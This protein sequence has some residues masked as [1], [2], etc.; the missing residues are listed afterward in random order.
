VGHQRQPDQPGQQ[1]RFGAVDHLGRDV[2]EVVGRRNDVRRG[3]GRQVAM[4]ISAMA[5]ATQTG[6]W[7]WPIS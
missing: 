2:L 3:V 1:H 6:L 7:I 5:T 4:M